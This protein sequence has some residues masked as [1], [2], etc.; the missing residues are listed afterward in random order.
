MRHSSA[1]SPSSGF[2]GVGH[3]RPRRLVRPHAE[4]VGEI[5]DRD[6]LPQQVGISQGPEQQVVV[7]AD[8]EI[9]A[10]GSAGRSRGSP[11]RTVPVTEAS[12]T[13]RTH[14]SRQPVPRPR[15]GEPA[16]SFASRSRP[17]STPRPS[18]RS[19][20][21]NARATASRPVASSGTRTCASADRIVES[22]SCQTRTA[23][24]VATVTCMPCAAAGPPC[25]LR[26]ISSRCETA[27]SVPD[28]GAVEPTIPID[29]PLAASSRA[30]SAMPAGSA[31]RAARARRGSAGLA[32]RTSSTTAGVV[33]RSV[34]EPG[35]ELPLG[36]RVGDRRQVPHPREVQLPRRRGEDVGVGDED[37]GPS[38]L[39][40]AFRAGD[41]KDAAVGDE[42]VD[43][44][45]GLDRDV[46]ATG[47]LRGHLRDVRERPGPDGDEQPVRT[48][49]GRPRARRSPR[50]REPSPCRAGPPGSRAARRADPRPARPACGT[51]RR[52]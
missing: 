3:D 44:A 40:G 17:S 5:D 52:R 42:T 9:L 15:T 22:T 1:P 4:Q 39:D 2:R 12:V 51:A 25:R 48:D 26:A 28:A 6:P 18:A 8:A 21:A 45:G 33:R 14:P 36:D 11:R 30:R 43:A 47:A 32:A 29:S 31:S 13:A 20:S 34:T 38:R 35:G 46:T 50:R 19:N 37:V 16:A 10:P 7:V 49:L 23:S 24:R 27:C 41:D